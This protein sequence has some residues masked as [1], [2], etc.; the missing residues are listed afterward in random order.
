MFTENT[1]T[2]PN[3][4]DIALRCFDRELMSATAYCPF[5]NDDVALGFVSG[6]V[7]LFCLRTWGGSE[8]DE[9]KNDYLFKRAFAILNLE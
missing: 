1:N 3:I 7:S 9:E 8:I 6:F 2:V 4:S 5:Q